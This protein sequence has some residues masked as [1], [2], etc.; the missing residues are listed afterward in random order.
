M[1]A[2]P[3]QTPAPSADSSDRGDSGNLASDPDLAMADDKF[4]PS[5]LP[6]APDP[7]SS[8]PDRGS[9][10]E[11]SSLPAAENK[12][13]AVTTTP[14]PAPSGSLSAVTYAVIGLAVLAV[15]GYFGWNAWQNPNNGATTNKSDKGK[16][17]ANVGTTGSADMA[18]HDIF[19]ACTPSIVTLTVVTKALAVKMEGMELTDLTGENPILVGSVGDGEY[20]LFDKGKPAKIAVGKLKT[21][22]GSLLVAVKLIG[23]HP[24]IIPVSEKGEPLMRDGKPVMLAK[25]VSLEGYS[26]Q[27]IGSGFYVRPD[28]VATN[29]H[30]VSMGGLGPPVSRAGWPR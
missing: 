18:P 19:K 7:V 10:T 17:T 22:K 11:A 25:G 3:D 4:L 29:C 30:V 1:P 27:A 2:L 28:I 8:L 12:T 16:E 26:E 9:A 13:T 23:S 5:V 6:A 21:S 15:A 20:S 24:V 14:K